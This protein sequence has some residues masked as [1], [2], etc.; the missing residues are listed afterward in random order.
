MTLY[1]NCQDLTKSFGPRVLFEGL[2]FSIFSGHR[3]GL[4]G[5][6][7]AGKSTL[8][9]ILSGSERANEGTISAKRGLKVGYVPQT[10]DFP[11]QDAFELLLESFP[12][13]DERPDYEKELSVK[14]WLSKLGFTGDEPSAMRL[15]GGW[16]KRLSLAKELLLSPDLLLLDEPT[17]HLDLEG[18]LWLEKFL[19]REAPSFLLVSHDRYFLQNM[20]NRTIEI[21][22]VYPNGLFS[23]EGPY[24]QFLE[25]KEEFLKGQLQQERSIASKARKELDWLRQSPKA[26]TS[27]SKSRVEDAHEI[28]D[29]LSQ[30]QKR[31][32]Q[33]RAAVDFAATS[34]ETQK[35]LV[36]KN[37]SKSAGDRVL[38]HH[39]DFTL[40]PGKKIGLMGPNGSGKTTLLKLIAGE[41][42]PDQGTI[43]RADALKI[44][45]FDQHRMQLPDDI[46][47][48]QAL[49]PKG[50]FISFR[51]Q[52]IHVNGWCKRFLFSP[53]LLDMPLAKLSGGERAR[54]AIAHLMLQPADI[55]LL[56]EPTNDLDI[57]TLETLEESLLEFPGA[58]VLIT[59]D[60]CMLDRVCNTLL[61]LGNLE[62]NTF[63]ADYSQWE[64]AQKEEEVQK[65][66]KE[67]KPESSLPKGKLTYGEK[68]E[69]EQIE[70]KI[71]KLEEEVRQLNGQLENPDVAEQPEQLQ[72]LCSQIGLAENQIEQLYLRWEELEKKLRGTQ[73]G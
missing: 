48:R 23:I 26:R 8:L 49:S 14:T 68:L 57:A 30:I 69:Y 41:T 47:L 53:D 58:L 7:G 44:V 72:T 25:K 2:S 55:L 28:L 59:H 10:C 45:Y 32:V 35:L 73:H 19:I 67:L 39:L 71:S 16:K 33:K 4:I 22:P 21:N 29:E 61:A 51:G 36:A 64:R 70:G 12:K 52:M 66:G 37:L 5:P 60:R 17:N 3:V 40:S 18:I 46:T 63:F 54:I 9:K 20:V 31:N 24:A 56:D 65:K 1:L 43:K 34:R 62:Q 50:D 27:K 6:N 38:F 15:S 11:D 42:S 13:E